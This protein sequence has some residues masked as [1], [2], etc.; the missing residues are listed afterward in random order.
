MLDLILLHLKV[1]ATLPVSLTHFVFLRV[2]SIEL[3]LN[4]HNLYLND[5]DLSVGLILLHVSLGELLADSLHLGV[6]H[7]LLFADFLNFTVDDIFLGT[8]L[9]N[10][11]LHTS[12]F[13]RHWDRVL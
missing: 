11:W 4:L 10:G 6:E 13:L 1:K 5:F 9:F 3:L 2:K 8:E 7:I 12:E